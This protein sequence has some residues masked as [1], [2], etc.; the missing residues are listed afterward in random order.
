[1]K[2]GFYNIQGGTGKTTIAANM[3]YYISDRIKTI[4]IDCDVYGGTGALLFGL[5]NEPNTLNTY[6]DGECGLNDIIHE[7]NNL[8]II[9]CD[10]TPNA[11]NTDMDQK[12]FLDVIK[13]ADENYDV[14]ILDLPPNITENNLLFSSENIFNKIIIVAEDSIPGIANT[15]K[16]IE[17]LNALSIEIVGIIVNK[18]RGIVDFEGILDNVVAII[19]YDKKVEY[20][21]LDGVPIVEKKSS[22]S[23]ELSFLADELTESYIE[24]DL[25]TLR[26]LKIAKEFRGSIIGKDENNGKDIDKF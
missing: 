20:Q 17:L 5:E 11:F 16:T 10:T 4:Y 14:V 6:L 13:F 25:A 2:L 21:W 3:A 12:K 9:A 8:S 23:K 26:A 22:F 24:K 19:P 15:L 1:M 7:Y 18:D